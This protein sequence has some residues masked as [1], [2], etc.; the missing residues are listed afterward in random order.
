MAILFYG[1]F[2]IAGH[3]IRN[4]LRTTMSVVEEAAEGWAAAEEERKQAAVKAQTAAALQQQNQKKNNGMTPSPLEHNPEKKSGK[5]FSLLPSDKAVFIV[6]MALSMVIPVICGLLFLNTLSPYLT[7]SSNDS[8]FQTVT[9][10]LNLGISVFTMLIFL[11]IM[12]AAFFGLLIEI[13]YIG[14][15]LL[16]ELNASLETKPGETAFPVKWLIYTVTIVLICIFWSKT[17]VFTTDDLADILTTGQIFI[18]PVA[19]AVI[20][21]V[22]FILVDW[23]TNKNN[24]NFLLKSQK[25]KDIKTMLVDI[26]VDSIAALLN[27][28]KFITSDFLESIQELAMDD[29]EEQI[30]E[31]SEEKSREQ[32]ESQVGGDEGVPG[33]REEK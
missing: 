23:I 20:T 5:G 33:R 7:E 14:K 4:A 21:P 25:V 1:I 31:S 13:W 24:W 32:V 9:S 16:Q 18:Y 12:W 27:F 19:I 15:R 26:P 17:Q 6:L 2:R 22:Y 29:E 8:G 10:I 3:L 28:L 30:E 11:L